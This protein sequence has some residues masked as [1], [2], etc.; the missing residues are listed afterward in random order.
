MALTGASDPV[1]H[2]VPELRRPPASRRRAAD[3]R[4]GSRG[5]HPAGHALG[6]GLP[7][8]P[9]C[10]RTKRSLTSPMSSSPRSRCEATS[11]SCRGRTCAARRP[12]SGTSR[13]PIST[14]PTR[15]STPPATASR[16]NGRSWTAHAVCSAARG[17]RAPR[18]KRQR[19]WTCR[20]SSSRWRRSGRSPMALRSKR[21]FV[22]SWTSTA[23]GSRR[24]ERTS[25]RFK[26]VAAKPRT[27]S[28][29]SPGSPP[30]GSSGASPCWHR[31]RT[32]SMRSAWRTA[33]WPGR[34]GSGSESRRRAGAPSSSPSFS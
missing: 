5:A 12:R 8:E 23:P 7:R 1:V 20:A 22:R 21:H 13:W 6:F 27:S 30:T 17:S 10:R 3:L 16:P 26:E 19:L 32:H 2:D 29:A 24:S 11:L 18:W 28:C 9:P 31:T 15:P 14:T 25:P 4:A 34:S 33:P